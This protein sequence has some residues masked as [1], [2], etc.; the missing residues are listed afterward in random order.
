MCWYVVKRVPSSNYRIFADIDEC[1]RKTD[2][3]KKPLVC[4]NTP[5]SFECVCPEGFTLTDDKCVG[6]QKNS[7]KEKG[8]LSKSVVS[9][10]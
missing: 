6:K 3:C 7:R 2:N 4:K 9:C 5:G 8:W 10:Y 1:S